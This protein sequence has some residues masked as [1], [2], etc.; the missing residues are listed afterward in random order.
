MGRLWC[1]LRLKKNHY[2]GG[3]GRE[4]EGFL[5]HELSQYV[6]NIQVLSFHC[7][8]FK[9]LYVFPVLQRHTDLQNTKPRLLYQAGAIKD[10]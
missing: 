3:H 6:H 8:V 2:Q 1:I 4:V 9:S 10:V 7:I 5:H